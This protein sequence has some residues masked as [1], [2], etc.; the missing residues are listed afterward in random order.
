MAQDDVVIIG[1]GIIGVSTAYFLA[2]SGV[3]V[4]L[5]EKGEIGAGS[6]SGNAG[7]IC[8]GHST[9]IPAPGV[10]TQGLKWLLDAASPFYIKPRL[11]KDLVSWLWRFQSFCNQKSFD[12]AV[13]LLRDWQ[14]ASLALFPQLIEQEK[15]D[16]HFAQKGSMIL[17]KT[18]KGFAEGQHE[19]AILQRF[20]LAMSVLNGDEARELETAV[21]PDVIGGIY[22][23]EDAH[24]A[25]D[26]FVRGLAQAAQ[27]YGA[28]ILTQTEVMGFEV[29]NGRITTLNTTNG[30][31]E[32][33]EVV[34]A[35]GA[36]STAVTRDLNLHIPMQ[37]AK[38]YSITGR[39]PAPSP[40]MPLYLGEARVAV[41]PMG[42]NLRLAGTLELAG[43]DFSI[44]RRRVQAIQD[45]ANAYLVSANMPEPV[46][47]WSGM[48]PCTPDGLPYV[49]R[50]RQY[51]NLIAATGHAMLGLSMGP[52]T[53]QVAAELVLGKRPS[54][55]P[56]PFHVERFSA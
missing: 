53:G 41:T 3:P 38:G 12:T 15:L 54:L 28:T 8:P 23:P 5:I 27:A 47:I 10:L 45:A 55:D 56:A 30:S 6:S 31:R 33:K 46:E 51:D 25:P 20:G 16:C 32:I 35:A 50:S 1:G 42:P 26:L 49:G 44:N 13:P 36:W 39:Q 43:F 40:Q 2:R 24:I 9:P 18:E 22:S 19:A 17:Y 29:E 11:D 7:F 34:L 37:P 4:T 48:R 21:H 52:I 14:R